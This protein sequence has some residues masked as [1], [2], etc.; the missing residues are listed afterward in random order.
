MAKDKLKKIE[1]V[2]GGFYWV[3]VGT[4]GPFIAQWGSGWKSKCWYFAGEETEYTP[5]VVEILSERLLPPENVMSSVYLKKRTEALA[6]LLANEANFLRSLGWTPVTSGLVTTFWK[7]DGIK[8]SQEEAVRRVKFEEQ[9]YQ[10]KMH[11][12]L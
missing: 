5:D 10:K 2:D 7:K 6:R 12:V 4:N 3:R 11:E 1:L 9:M 8:I